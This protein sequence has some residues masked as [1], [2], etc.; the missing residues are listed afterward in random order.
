M[1]Q[2]LHTASPY[3]RHIGSRCQRLSSVRSARYSLFACCSVASTLRHS[4]GHPH[5]TVKARCCFETT[6]SPS[7]AA[8]SSQTVSVRV[9]KTRSRVLSAGNWYILDHLLCSLPALFALLDGIGL[10]DLGLRRPWC[11]DISRGTSVSSTAQKGSVKSSDCKRA[12]HWQG[13]QVWK[14]KLDISLASPR[15]CVS[16][17]TCLCRAAHA[18][19]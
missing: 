16:S 7:C 10:N 1:Q 17:W 14:E 3:G 13:I 2:N 8:S 11:L 9:S 15:H 19:A 6:N 4:P 12:L 5:Q 18:G